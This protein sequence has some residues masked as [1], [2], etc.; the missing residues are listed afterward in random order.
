M[1]KKILIMLGLAV[2]S[3]SDAPSQ[4]PHKS[5]IDI[6]GNYAKINE[7]ANLF[8]KDFG[9]NFTKTPKGHIQTDIAGAGA[10]AGLMLLREVVPDLDS[11]PPGIVVISDVHQGQ[12]EL[13]EFMSQVAVN[14]GLE[15]KTGWGMSIAET[16]KPMMD[17]LEL[18]SRLESS[19]YNICSQIGL[20]KQYY[21][22]AAALTAMK[23][24]AAGNGMH[25]LDQQ[26]GKSLA[27]YYIVAGSKTA[28]HS[29][30]KK[31]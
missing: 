3:I 30:S 7:T 24:V 22:Y 10:I 13:L 20:P 25:L 17:T 31:K 9:P 11:M 21:S 16:D 26:R 4:P 19:F 28:P 12:V 2:A 18:T 29:L 5:S 23:L 27:F 6:A 8:L 15:A 14:M 1:L